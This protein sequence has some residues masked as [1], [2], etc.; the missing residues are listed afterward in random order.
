MNNPRS[1]ERGRGRERAGGRDDPQRQQHAGNREDWRGAG[2]AENENRQTGAGEDR[3]GGYSGS[4][5][6]RGSRQDSRGAQSWDEERFAYAEDHPELERHR[7]EW[8][9]EGRDSQ[10]SYRD[11]WFRGPDRYYW[12]NRY[13][14][15]AQLGPNGPSDFAPRGYDDRH[16]FETYRSNRFGQP[17]W[18]GESFA[19]GRDAWNS[20]DRMY[21]IPSGSEPG[22]YSFNTASGGGRAHN[23]S[24]SNWANDQ[25]RIPSRGV[26]TNPG[27]GRR[28]PKGY[29]RSDERIRDDVCELLYRTHDVD[30]SNVSVESKNGTL[31]LEGSVTDRRMK[32]RIEDLCEQ[33]IGVNDVDNRI[34][35]VREQAAPEASAGM[36]HDADDRF[37]NSPG[38]SSSKKGAH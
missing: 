25:D 30:V 6:D 16:R 11:D 22:G 23:W 7:R 5:A 13:G 10:R 9:G 12:Q 20:Q 4:Y 26:G 36:G 3:F 34:R 2:R 18:T 32:H 29:T 35:V 21:G 24:G 19:G 38:S 27:Q 28:P 37:Q 1:N 33:C 8:R 15:G 17:D 14:G 31:T